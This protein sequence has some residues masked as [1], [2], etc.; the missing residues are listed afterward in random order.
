MSVQLMNRMFTP[1]MIIGQPAMIIGQL[2]SMSCRMRT[3]L[4]VNSRRLKAAVL[5]I[6]VSQNSNDQ[7]SGKRSRNFVLL[8]DFLVK[9]L[10]HSADT[11]T[12]LNLTGIVDSEDGASAQPSSAT[13]STIIEY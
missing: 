4:N 3:L 2:A 13:L 6:T 1:S 8:I 7:T 12:P 10:T 5:F 9:S 11:Y